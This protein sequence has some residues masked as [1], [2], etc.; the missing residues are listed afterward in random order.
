MWNLHVEDQLGW[1]QVRPLCPILQIK[2]V[3]HVCRILYFCIN[4]KVK[5]TVAMKSVEEHNLV[6]LQK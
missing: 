5:V 6:V 4:T 2:P 1:S 3:L